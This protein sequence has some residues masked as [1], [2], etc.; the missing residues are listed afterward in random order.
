MQIHKIQIQAST[1]LMKA[2]GSLFPRLQRFTFNSKHIN[3]FFVL[4][5]W[6]CVNLSWHLR[7]WSMQCWQWTPAKGSLPTKFFHIRY[8]HRILS[9]GFLFIN[10]WY[11]R[12]MDLLI[13]TFL[14]QINLTHSGSFPNQNHAFFSGWQV[15]I[16]QPR[17]FSRHRT[18]SHW[19]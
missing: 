19:R 7:S 16:S 10:F 18:P 8:S 3:W 17:I 6:K 1:A 2:T 11:I 15:E 9:Q 12:L 5:E 4:S 14:H 13:F